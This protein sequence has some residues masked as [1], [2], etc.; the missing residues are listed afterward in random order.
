MIVQDVSPG[1]LPGDRL[2][3]DVSVADGAALTVLGQGAT[4]IYP[5]EHGIA[6]ASR[7]TLRVRGT[8]TL[9]WL[10]GPLIPFRDARFEARTHVLLDNASRFASMEVITPGRT[11]MGECNAYQR[12][13]LR[14]RIDVGGRAR[15]I[16]RA[17]LDPRERPTAIAGSQGAF[18][19]SG[20]LIMIGY[21]AP[22]ALDSPG[23]GLWL[24]AD[25]GVE[26]MV[27]RGL[28]RAAEPLRKALLDLLHCAAKEIG[29]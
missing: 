27:V 23:D 18:T 25:G 16:E 15:L 1:L 21:S 12:L 22:S 20:T 5:S 19:C 13:D 3:T 9:W 10:P 14:L 2:E 7:M 28:A 29:R 4:R 26:L 6:A 11:A 17:L 24:G 8:G